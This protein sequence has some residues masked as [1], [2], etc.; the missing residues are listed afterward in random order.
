MP[1]KDEFT[2]NTMIAGYANSGKVIEAHKLF[3]NTPKRSSITWS[4]LISGYCKSGL[5]FESI[6][7]FC[8]MQ[9]EGYKPSQFTLGS[10]LRMCS[11]N[12]L[13]SRGEQVH[14]YAIKTQF[15]AN[16]FVVTGL[17][18]M[19]AQCK[20]VS[21]AKCLFKMMSYGK[22]HVTWTAMI[23]G[24]SRNQDQLGAIECFR[25]MRAEGVEANQY[26]QGFKREALLL[27]KKMH[28]KN[29]KIDDFTYPSV[30]NCFASLN[31]AKAS[32]S[33]HCLAIKTGFGEYVLEQRKCA[34]D[35]DS[36]RRSKMNYENIE[37][38]GVFGH[39]YN[40][41]SESKWT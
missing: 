35:R 41:R 34:R 13:L 39:K 8:E 40:D 2:W 27:F 29:M 17:V 31:D 7:L 28:T 15:D 38:D 37:T 26:T 9:N 22:N 10:I 18:D 11:T 5:E 23:T 3:V 25:D 14:G 21:T 33:V 19:Y 30:L 6:R 16:V 12:E 4:S 24:Y 1:E 36:E 32:K 20:Q